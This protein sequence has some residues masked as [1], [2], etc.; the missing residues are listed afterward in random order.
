MQWFNYERNKQ[1]HLPFTPLPHNFP[2]LLW[3]SSRGSFQQIET[4]HGINCQPNLKL[5]SIC[6]SNFKN[7][8]TLSHI[9]NWNV[10]VV[11]FFLRK[12]SKSIIYCKNSTN[13]YTHTRTKPSDQL[14]WM[15]SDE[16]IILSKHLE[17]LQLSSVEDLFNPYILVC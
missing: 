3:V 16:K 2:I 12:F 8:Q 5:Y 9:G 7:Y 4:N 10:F 15:V 14:L 11:V 17:A 13:Q 6:Q 1:A